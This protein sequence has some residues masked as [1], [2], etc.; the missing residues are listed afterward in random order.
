MLRPCPEG[1]PGARLG[2]NFLSSGDLCEQLLRFRLWFQR[3]PRRTQVV[4][5]PPSLS[6]SFIPLRTRRALQGAN[7]EACFPEL[8]PL[9]REPSVKPL[10]VQVEMSNVDTF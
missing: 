1:A 5:D 7:P 3:S 9:L 4:G 2:K 6:E 8:D 10:T